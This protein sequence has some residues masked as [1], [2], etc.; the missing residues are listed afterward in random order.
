M[1]LPKE[2]RQKMINIMYLVLTTLLALNVSKQIVHAFIVVNTGLQLTNENTQGQTKALEAKFDKALANDPVKT[3]PFS[4]A[5]K[6]IISKADKMV[7]DIQKEKASLVK[8]VDK[9]PWD[10]D[11]KDTMME[12]VD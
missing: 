8:R 1:S 5:A 12:N 10:L 9:K 2:P 6:L 11:K 3:K 4:D 7:E